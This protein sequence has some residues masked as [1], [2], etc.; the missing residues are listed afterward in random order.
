MFQ[1]CN[2]FANG[3]SYARKLFGSVK[4][5]IINKGS[6]CCCIWNLQALGDLRFSIANRAQMLYFREQEG[7]KDF[8]FEKKKE[9]QEMITKLNP[10]S[11]RAFPLC[12]IANRTL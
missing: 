12:T 5:G 3:Q 7:A 10:M 4:L 8:N 1:R 6:F 11:T 9:R 2:V